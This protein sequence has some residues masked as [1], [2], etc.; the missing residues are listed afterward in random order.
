MIIT[1]YHVDGTEFEVTNCPAFSESTRRC[2]NKDTLLCYCKDNK[3]CIIKN[4]VVALAALVQVTSRQPGS[5]ESVGA[6]ACFN[7]FIVEK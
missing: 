6:K 5:A 4:H 3:N 2:I 7:S 1:D